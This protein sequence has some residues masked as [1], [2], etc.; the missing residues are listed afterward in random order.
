MEAGD[1]AKGSWGEGEQAAKSSLGEEEQTAKKC[2]EGRGNRP[3][4]KYLRGEGEKTVQSILSPSPNKYW[5][6]LGD[7]NVFSKARPPT[8]I[9]QVMHVK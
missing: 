7:T 4:R 6:L 1:R 5:N 3:C 9:W 2:F 8:Y